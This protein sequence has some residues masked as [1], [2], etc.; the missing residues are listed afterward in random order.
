M[1]LSMGKNTKVSFQK[2]SS[3]YSWKAFLDELN[4]INTLTGLE[5]YKAVGFSERI[6]SLPTMGKKELNDT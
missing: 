6:T 5:V 1:L 2:L 3:W 4:T